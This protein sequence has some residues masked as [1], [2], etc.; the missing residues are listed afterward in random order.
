M[1]GRKASQT[2]LELYPR[3][4]PM[5]YHLPLINF[6]TRSRINISL[7]I[8]LSLLFTLLQSSVQMLPIPY[9]TL[10]WGIVPTLLI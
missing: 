9:Q 2:H 7:L 4:H 6:L 8:I 1:T 5:S 10:A 3:P